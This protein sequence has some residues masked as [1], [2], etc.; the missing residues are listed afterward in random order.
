MDST[1]SE[2]PATAATV[3]GLPR[4]ERLGTELE[5][6]TSAGR[7][8]S[9]G[10]P[11]GLSDPQAGRSPEVISIIIEPVGRRYRAWLDDGT[12]LISATRAPYCA[13]ARALIAGGYDPSAILEMRRLG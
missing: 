7:K 2:K 5:S 6:Q 3:N 12:P 8:R 13:S 1:K 10:G 9:Q 11:K 4:N